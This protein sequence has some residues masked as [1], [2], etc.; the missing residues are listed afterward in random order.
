ME[1][2][3]T[4]NHVFHLDMNEYLSLDVVN[5]KNGLLRMR[6]KKEETENRKEKFNEE[7]DNIEE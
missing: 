3:P 5:I 2:F 7:D 1:Q 4:A 6:R